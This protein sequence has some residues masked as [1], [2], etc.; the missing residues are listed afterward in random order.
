MDEKLL[1]AKIEL[2]L[3]KARRSGRLHSI[4]QLVAEGTKEPALGSSANAE[5]TDDKA[6]R[7]WHSG[8]GICP[9][10]IIHSAAEHNVSS[11]RA[12]HLLQPKPAT[13]SAPIT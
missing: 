1:D 2:Q 11:V 4:L 12:P 3:E 13:Q 7:R 5:L 6:G 10:E 9:T 8:I